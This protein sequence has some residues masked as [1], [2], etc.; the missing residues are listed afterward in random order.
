MKQL[1]LTLSLPLALAAA[2]PALAQE[3]GQAAPLQE[4]AAPQ[5]EAQ[6]NDDKMRDGLRLFLDGLSEGMDR[7][8]DGL[9]DKAE[10]A[11]P[12]LRDFIARLGPAWQELLGDI[13][14][15]SDYEAPQILPNGDIL[16]RRKD[17][18]PVYVPPEPGEN[19]DGS[20]DL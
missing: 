12:A 10:E 14:D 15:F 19:P 16:I 11:A 18:A 3:D 4:E 17:D 9:G 7:T 20:V 8:F 6:D 1:I 5:A 2:T 13:K